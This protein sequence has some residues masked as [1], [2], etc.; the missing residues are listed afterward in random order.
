MISRF[1]QP[2]EKVEREFDDI[3]EALAFVT[4]VRKNKPRDGSQ[5]IR[6]YEADREFTRKELKERASR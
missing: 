4:E 1:R 5:R 2:L 3:G 6:F